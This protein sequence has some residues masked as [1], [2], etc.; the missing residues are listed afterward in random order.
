[1]VYVYMS[2]AITGDII[3][4]HSEK[5]KR[6]TDFLS[7]STIVRTSTFQKKTQTNRSILFLPFRSLYEVSPLAGL[8]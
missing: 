7:V 4:V 2:L 8:C 5:S 6:F 1:M 3:T